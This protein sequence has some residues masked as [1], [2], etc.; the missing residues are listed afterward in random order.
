MFQIFFNCS[1][2]DA[3]VESSCM[4]VHPHT[5]SH[6]CL[7]YLYISFRHKLI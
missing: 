6:I 2:V 3:F 5:H 4:R 7:S 1:V